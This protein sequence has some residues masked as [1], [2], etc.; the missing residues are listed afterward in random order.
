MCFLVYF[1][2]AAPIHSCVI[3]IDIVWYSNQK[4]TIID[5]AITVDTTSIIV[6]KGYVITNSL[7]DCGGINV[8]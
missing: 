2:H 6:K 4:R 3:F 7:I 1:G 5:N 8:I